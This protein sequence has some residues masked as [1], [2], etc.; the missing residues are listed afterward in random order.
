MV[1]T[2]WEIP[3][4]PKAKNNRDK[5][6]L[7]ETCC[8]CIRK[9][10]IYSGEKS[11]FQHF[12]ERIKMKIYLVGVRDCEGEAVNCACATKVRAEEELFSLRDRLVEQ[13]KDAMSSSRPITDYKAMIVALSG[14]DYQNWNNYPHQQPFIEEMELMK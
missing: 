13:W 3:L 2:H 5:N 8:P 14:N 6:P 7:G 4:E 10:G 12:N 9:K 1:L 11:T